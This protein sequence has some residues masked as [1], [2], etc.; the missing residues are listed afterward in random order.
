MAERPDAPRTISGQPYPINMNPSH[1]ISPLIVS[2]G[3]RVPINCL[4]FVSES[5]P[6]PRAVEFQRFLRDILEATTATS[7]R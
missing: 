1:P 3:V 5:R 2:L 6:I 7:N 4:A